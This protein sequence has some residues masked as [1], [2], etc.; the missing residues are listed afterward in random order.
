MTKTVLITGASSGIGKASTIEFARRGYQVF[1]G[2]RNSR[3]REELEAMRG[4][5]PLR[6][7]VT[8]PGDIESAC[9]RVEY[10]TGGDG[11]YA[12]INNAGITYA[13]PFE[14]A[15]EERA[16][17]VMDVNVMAPYAITRMFLPL[18]KLHNA[19]NRVKSRVI[20]L[21]SWA[22]QV[23]QPF[24]PFYNAS[25]AALMALSESMYY[26]LGMLDIHVVLA[27][28]GVTRTPL[29]EKTTEDAMENLKGFPQQGR[30][31]YQPYFD[32]Y[33]GMSA[34]SSRS[35]LLPKPEAVAGKLFRIAEAARPGFR[36][37]LAMDALVVDAL[38]VRFVPFCWRAG[39]IR[40]MYKLKR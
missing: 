38:V 18:L 35:A 22:G 33:A 1:A 37:N 9:R 5:H 10:L 2:Y 29:L 7:D 20:N 28:P 19:S 12:I 34:A 24:I 8:D 14:F 27:S 26:D 40:R 4:V 3:D 25:K 16:R 13:A 6:L 39:L 21:A 32:H 36:Y 30:E 15:R 17:Q 11:L 23:G 31:F